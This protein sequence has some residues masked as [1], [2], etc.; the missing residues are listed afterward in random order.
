MFLV[1][2]ATVE[3]LSIVEQM[4]DDSVEFIEINDNN[5]K[6]LQGINF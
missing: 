3:H 1:K 6:R 2:K 4:S 5:Q